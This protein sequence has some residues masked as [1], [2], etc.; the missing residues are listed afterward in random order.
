MKYRAKCTNCIS[1]LLNITKYKDAFFCKDASNR[2]IEVDS[3]EEADLIEE[4]NKQ[5]GELTKLYE[6]LIKLTQTHE[7]L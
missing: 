6:R 5:K 4:I 7:T 3:E 1:Q 2:Y